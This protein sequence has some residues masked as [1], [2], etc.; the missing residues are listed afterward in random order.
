MANTQNL[1][2]AIGGD[3]NAVANHQADLYDDLNAL[4]AKLIAL[5]AK[6]D[7]DSG[8]NGTDFAS[9]LTPAALKTKK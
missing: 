4:R 2:R 5:L 1:R 7:A 3:V 6:L 8:V 9:T